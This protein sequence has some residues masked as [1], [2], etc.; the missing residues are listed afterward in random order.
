MR[1]DLNHVILFC[2][3]GTLLSI[4]WTA[5]GRAFVSNGQVE[6]SKVTKQRI[7]SRDLAEEAKCL[8]SQ[9]NLLESELKRRQEDRMI[10]EEKARFDELVE[11]QV[12]RRLRVGPAALMKFYARNGVGHQEARDFLRLLGVSE[13]EGLSFEDF[14]SNLI[15]QAIDFVQDGKRRINRK[16]KVLEEQ[17]EATEKMLAS[18]PVPNRDVSIQA[19]CIA[20]LTYLLPL[21]SAVSLGMSGYA[22]DFAMLSAFTPF[23]NSWMWWHWIL[24]LMMS[25]IANRR[26]LPLILRFNL[27]QAFTLNLLLVSLGSC[28]SIL[29][30]PAQY[31][32]M[33]LFD[34]IVRYPSSE[35]QYQLAALLLFTCCL[36][37]Y[38]VC[39]TL[40]GCLPDSIP[41]ISSTARK[42]LGK[43]RPEGFKQSPAS[44]GDSGQV[45]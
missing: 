22:R 4:D 1:K 34:K 13:K 23:L 44:Q 40:I 28:L 43:L 39:T 41:F 11:G 15:S 42:S 8:R 32:E 9:V 33:Y 6:S 2:C 35:P 37:A 3:L 10:Q 38:S 45:P 17:N 27:Q 19:R 12:G 24:A 26:K 31:T 14:D 21:I 29:Q 36:I 5:S 25:S 18:L 20:S 16:L 30:G 7:P